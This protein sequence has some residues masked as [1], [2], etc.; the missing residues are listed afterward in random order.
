MVVN[1]FAIHLGGPRFIFLASREKFP[2]IHNAS[3]VGMSSRH[4]ALCR[5]HSAARVSG[6]ALA[7]LPRARAA[8]Q[9]RARVLPLRFSRPPLPIRGAIAHAASLPPPGARPPLLFVP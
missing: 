9:T 2:D 8:R 6:G 3:A 1:R 4:I 5:S 7:S